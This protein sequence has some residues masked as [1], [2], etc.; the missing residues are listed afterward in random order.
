MGHAPPP[1][2][3]RRDHDPRCTD[4]ARVKRRASCRTND[5]MTRDA[6][7]RG[8]SLS[9]FGPMCLILATRSKALAGKWRDTLK[10]MRGIACWGWASASPVFPRPFWPCQPLFAGRSGRPRPE[11][12]PSAW[13]CGSFGLA[14]MQLPVGWALIQSGQR[15]NRGQPAADCRWGG[16]PLFAVATAARWHINLANGA[17]RIGARR[18]LMAA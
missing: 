11:T 5:D 6:R 15:R 4:P 13:G 10:W 17:D 3:Q 9:R 16:V 1:E 2:V 14:A 8:G 7:G 18:C 12:S